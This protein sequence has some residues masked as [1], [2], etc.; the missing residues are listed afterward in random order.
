[1]RSRLRLRL[2][3]SPGATGT[4]AGPIAPKAV[5]GTLLPGA[6]GLVGALC[7]PCAFAA[8]AQPKQRVASRMADPA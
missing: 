8:A 3:G 1:M 4:F 5:V 6:I 2:V 7:M